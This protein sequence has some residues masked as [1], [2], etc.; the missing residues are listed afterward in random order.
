MDSPKDS[1]GQPATTMVKEKISSLPY[2]PRKLDYNWMMLSNYKRPDLK[3]FGKK[4]CGSICIVAVGKISWA[5]NENLYWLSR[6]VGPK[7]HKLSGFQQQ[8]FIPSQ[9]WSSG[10]QNQGVRR[11][12]RLRVSDPFLVS[13]WFLAMA[14][15][16][17][18]P[19]AWSYI[20]L[21][22]ASV[23]IW[24]SLREKNSNFLLWIRIPV[25]LN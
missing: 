11:F 13:P 16:P 10:F 24:S 12:L 19:L 18:F 4:I 2:I 14:I 5:K 7:G 25:L 6:A 20:V 23:V 15:N 1:I 8:K 9:L 21:I 17:W 22:S 3:T